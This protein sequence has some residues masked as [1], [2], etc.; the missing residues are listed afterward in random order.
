MKNKKPTQNQINFFDKKVTIEIHPLA[1]KAFIAWSKFRTLRI[2]ASVKEIDPFYRPSIML[3]KGAEK[4]SYYFFNSFSYIE[5]EKLSGERLYQHCLVYQPDK[6]SIESLAWREVAD[7]SYQRDINHF[8]LL[9]TLQTGIGA[10]PKLLLAV[11][12]AR[13]LNISTYCQFAKIESHTFD[14][15]RKIA[16]NSGIKRS[17]CISQLYVPEDESWLLE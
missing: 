3:I 4:N 15:H 14:Y 7:L 1:E 6:F 12:G 16:R 13:E 5:C 9:R 8:E 11:I 17:K 10:R 2:R